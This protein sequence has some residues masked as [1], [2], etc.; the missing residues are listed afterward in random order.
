MSYHIIPCFQI[1]LNSLDLNKYNTPFKNIEDNINILNKMKEEIK[2][3]IDKINYIKIIRIFL[4]M[5]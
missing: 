5:I 4:K 2:S 1:G 3:F